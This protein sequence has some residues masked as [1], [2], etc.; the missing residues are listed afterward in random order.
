M[1]RPL[2]FF[3]VFMLFSAC[4]KLV[5]DSFPP[6]EK[7]PVVSGFIANDGLVGVH[8]SLTSAISKTPLQGLD[9]AYVVI[10]ASGG[11]TI[12]LVNEGEGW[13]VA[14]VIPVYGQ[15]Y[16]CEVSVPGYAVVKAS[17]LMPQPPVLQQVIHTAISGKDEE[18]ITY[19]SVS[20]TFEN[21]P[22]KTS[23]YEARI[24]LFRP[25]MEWQ[26]DLINFNDPILQNEGLPLALFNNDLINGKTYNM[27]INYMTRGY[28]NSDVYGERRTRLFPFVIELRSICHDYYQYA[29]SAKLYE[30]GRYPEFGLHANH[31][32]PLHSNTSSGYGVFVAYAS[33]ISDTIYPSY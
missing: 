3:T 7:I 8:V 16:H 27:T 30:T 22:S 13:Y 20:F 17:A 12:E 11:D 33:T 31:V 21:N 32:F 9:N 26:A 4:N 23:Y 1:K 14:D 24:R 19:P 28:I 18:G 2:F 6:F 10:Y 5:Q 25:D 29:R 15:T